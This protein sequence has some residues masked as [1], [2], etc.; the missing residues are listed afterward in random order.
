MSEAPPKR[1]DIK[2]YLRT[3]W[4][5]EQRMKIRRAV[6][7]TG[8]QWAREVMD[9]ETMRFVR[10]LDYKNL[11]ALEISG[12]YW[13]QVGFRSFTS[14]NYPEFDVCGERTHGADWDIIF[15]EQVL[16]HVPHPRRALENIF[17][18]LRPGGIL[19]VTTPFMIRIHNHPIDCTR[20][21]ETG[22]KF[23]LEEIGFAAER[24]ETGSWGN[25]QCLIASLKDWPKYNRWL[26]HSLKNDP[27]YPVVVWAFAT[28]NS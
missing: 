15:L 21:T 5:P 11:D 28:K 2:A 16:E 25:R 6:G 4:T 19:F 10:S 24:I 22:M 18:M 12:R 26:L 14:L 9:R 7:I 17:A 8:H 1:L 23:F 3:K 27:R 13:D 20:W